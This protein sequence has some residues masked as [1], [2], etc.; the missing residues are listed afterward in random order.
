M[1]VD[2]LN[3]AEWINELEIF[4]EKIRPKEEIRDKLDV[5]YKINDQTVIIHE[6]RPRWDNPRI[7]IEPEVAKAIYVKNKNHW[8]VYWLRGNLKD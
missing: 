7:K 2:I 6:I 8:K 1:T 5:G 3:T 4:L